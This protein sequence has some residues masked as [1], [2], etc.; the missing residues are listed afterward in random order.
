M[1]GGILAGR[2]AA[3][4]EERHIVVLHKILPKRKKI[5]LVAGTTMCRRTHAGA[6][7]ASV[8]LG[9]QHQRQHQRQRQH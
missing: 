4:P 9:R 6:T 7:I 8:S 3:A 2:R 5:G 1:R